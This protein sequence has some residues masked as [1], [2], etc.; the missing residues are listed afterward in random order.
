MNRGTTATLR[1]LAPG[2]SVTLPAYSL[3]AQ[4]SPYAARLRLEGIRITLK[5]SPAGII[6]TRATEEVSHAIADLL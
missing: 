4:V 6:A 1:A 2:E 3:P 5:Q